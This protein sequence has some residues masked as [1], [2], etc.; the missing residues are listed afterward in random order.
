VERALFT[1]EIRPGTEGEYR[2]R[3]DAIWPELIAALQEAGISNY[4]IF[5]QGTTMIAYAEC[6]PHAAT[7]FAKVGGTDINA[8]WSRWFEDIILQLADA[9]GKLF[10]AEE[11]WH[12]AENVA[13][14]AQ[15]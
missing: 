7:A 6:E 8:R 13:P 3:H 15:E 11:V 4:T 2:R 10:W 9:D 14:A 1:F 5:R 12:L